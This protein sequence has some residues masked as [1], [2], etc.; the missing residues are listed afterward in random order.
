MVDSITKY[1]PKPF[2]KYSPKT[3]GISILVVV[4]LIAIIRPFMRQDAGVQIAQPTVS[5]EAITLGNG[6]DQAKAEY[7]K[8]SKENDTLRKQMA[9]NEVIMSAAHTNVLGYQMVLC[10]KFRLVRASGVFVQTTA[11]CTSFQQGTPLA[12]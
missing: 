4:V 12:Q 6:V 7:D 3:I 2:M 5:K 8:A 9:D 11:D 1:T 10:S